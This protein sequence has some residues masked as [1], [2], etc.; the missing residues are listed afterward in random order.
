MYQSMLLLWRFGVLLY[1][2]ICLCKWRSTEIGHK[3]KEL[4]ERGREIRFVTYRSDAWNSEECFGG[5][6]GTL[7][8]SEDVHNNGRGNLP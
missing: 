2:E 6:A 1:C 8:V 7:K 3:E 5:H 4:M